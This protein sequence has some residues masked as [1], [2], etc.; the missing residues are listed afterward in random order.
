[1]RCRAAVSARRIADSGAE[2]LQAIVRQRYTLRRSI[3]VTSNRVVQDWGKYLC[4]TTTWTTILDRLMHPS[5]RG[6]VSG[7]RST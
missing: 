4:D 7:H 3:V 6:P 1:M 2:M 5:S